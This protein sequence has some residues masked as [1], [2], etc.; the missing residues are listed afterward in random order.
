MS[1]VNA[2]GTLPAE[3]CDSQIRDEL[4]NNPDGCEVKYP[5]KDMDDS[6]NLSSPDGVYNFAASAPVGTTLVSKSKTPSGILYTRYESTD[7]GWIC[8]DNEIL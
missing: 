2:F 4:R 6:Y 5:S 8:T 3:M 7:K 1:V